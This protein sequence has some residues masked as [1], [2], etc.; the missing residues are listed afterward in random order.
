MTSL[1][2]DIAGWQSPRVAVVQS[3]VYIEGGL[4]DEGSFVNDTWSYMYQAPTQFGSLYS[5]DL[6]QNISQSTFASQLNFTPVSL[7][8]SDIPVWVD[9]GIFYD[10]YN[11]YTF[12]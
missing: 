10:T 1:S 4:L 3:R 2:N 9:G 7:L 6:K 11:L 8:S 12:G 5:L